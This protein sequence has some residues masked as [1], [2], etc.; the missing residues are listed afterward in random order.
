MPLPTYERLTGTASASPHPSRSTLD[1]GEID[2]NAKP[3]M[4]AAVAMIAALLLPA[5]TIVT[6]IVGCAAWFVW[7]WWKARQP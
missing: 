3:E 5:W 6:G 4:I 1:P 7:R 2:V